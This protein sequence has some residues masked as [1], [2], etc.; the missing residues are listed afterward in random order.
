MLWLAASTRHALSESEF[1]RKY[2]LECLRLA[3]DC[4]QAARDVES[5]LLRAHFE[6]LA[7]MWAAQAE[8]DLDADIVKSGLN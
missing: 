7:K 1:L 3:E 2:A 8:Q 5:P 4:A 6:E